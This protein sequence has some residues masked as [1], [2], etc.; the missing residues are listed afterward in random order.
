MLDVGCGDGR[1]FKTIDKRRQLYTAGVDIFEPYLRKAKKSGVYD[2]LVLC[3]I[4]NLPF[5]MKSF[6]VLLCLSVLEHIKS[7]SDGLKLVE[8][9]EEVARQR[10]IIG[11][12]V[13]EYKQEMYDDNPYQEHRSSWVPAEF[14]R[15]GYKVRGYGLRFMREEEWLPRTPKPL[16]LLRYGIYGLVAPLV[17][18][19]PELAGH[20]ACTKNVI[21]RKGTRW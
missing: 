4:R 14:K 15:R 13:G 8:T 20:M 1:T 11:T 16:K 7:K 17:Y 12:P 6:D 3:D 21:K 18:F 10:V 2:G 9:M 5:Q 19:F